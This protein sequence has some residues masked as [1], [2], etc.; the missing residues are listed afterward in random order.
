MT[1]L[2]LPLL[3]GAGAAAGSRVRLRGAHVQLVDLARGRSLGLLRLGGAAIL[4]LSLS[5]SHLY[6]SAQRPCHRTF[7]LDLIS[8]RTV[9]TLPTADPALLLDAP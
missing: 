3:G 8:G 9:A 4:W 2:S 5:G 6:A 7:V 1:V